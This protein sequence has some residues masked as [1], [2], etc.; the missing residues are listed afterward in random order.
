VRGLPAR[1]AGAARDPR[2]GRL[3]SAARQ[4]A[5]APVK[6]YFVAERVVRDPAPRGRRGSLATLR[7]TLSRATTTAGTASGVGAPGARR[8]QG[9]SIRNVDPS[10]IR[11]V[12]EPGPPSAFARGLTMRDPGP[13]PVG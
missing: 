12:T 2:G 3:P 11:L 5:Q 1:R 7:V 10:P 4:G 13:T 6:R 8:Q 9:T